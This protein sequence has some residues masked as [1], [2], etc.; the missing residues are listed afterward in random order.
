MYCDKIHHT[1]LNNG[2]ELSKVRQVS[3]YCIFFKNATYTEILILSY[4]SE[5]MLHFVTIY[6]W[7]SVNQGK[8]YFDR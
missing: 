1:A 8:R 5:K 6:I 2:N 7:Y 3:I 4:N